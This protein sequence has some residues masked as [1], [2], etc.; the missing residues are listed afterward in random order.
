LHQH[1]RNQNPNMEGFLKVCIIAWLICHGQPKLLDSRQEQGRIERAHCCTADSADSSNLRACLD[2]R[3]AA[4]LQSRTAVVTMANVGSG[5]FS[6][7]DIAEFSTFQYA[8]LSNYAAQHEYLFRAYNSTAGFNFGDTI[9]SRWYKIKIL[10]DSVSPGGWAA[11]ADA[12][13]WIG[14][15]YISC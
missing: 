11:H 8:I 14:K 12:I 9:D 6:I 5:S 3:G 4:W 13:V 10:L 7:Q 2:D 1:L 15:C